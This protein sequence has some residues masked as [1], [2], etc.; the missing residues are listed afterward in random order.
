MRQ[1]GIIA[2]AGIVA[3]STMVERLAEGHVNARSLADGFGLV[4]GLTVWPVKRR[5][6]IVVFEVDEGPASA[7]R[8]SVA[9]KD[10][11]VLVGPR[12]PS[13][14]RAVTI[15][16]LPVGT[17]ARPSRRRRKLRQRY[18]AMEPG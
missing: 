16:A 10:R 1:A 2:A 15:M 7:A 18:S 3:L 8:F 13:A 4:A 11:G 12:G 9:L 14:F 6:N 17:L 5:T